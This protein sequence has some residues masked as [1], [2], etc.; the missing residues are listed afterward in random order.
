MWWN[1]CFRVLNNIHTYIRTR[2]IPF[3]VGVSLCFRIFFFRHNSSFKGC[4]DPGKIFSSCC[5]PV[6]RA[7]CLWWTRGICCAPWLWLPRWPGSVWHLGTFH[8]CS[9]GGASWG[10]LLWV[11]TSTCLG[12]F[13]W[14]GGWVW[15][16]WVLNTAPEVALLWFSSITI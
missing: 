7:S 11:G 1:C 5:C 14:V 2:S 10:G 13:S 8:G 6:G 16:I 3:F 4:W 9:A 12:G 15:C